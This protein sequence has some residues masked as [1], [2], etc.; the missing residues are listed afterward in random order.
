MS[1]LL[2]NV[3]TITRNGYFYGYNYSSNRKSPKSLFLNIPIK[4]IPTV[5]DRLNLLWI[6]KSKKKQLIPEYFGICNKDIFLPAAPFDR[7]KGDMSKLGDDIMKNMNYKTYD[8]KI[9]EY[10]YGEFKMKSGDTVLSGTYERGLPTNLDVKQFLKMRRLY[11]VE[12]AQKVNLL[13][14]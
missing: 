11:S 12:N 5:E 13:T 1:T 4:L 9:Y 14:Q 10:L 6:I 7:E 3:Q 2:N 8:S